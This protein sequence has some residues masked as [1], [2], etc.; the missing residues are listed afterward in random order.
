MATRRLYAA[1]VHL[2]HRRVHPP[3]SSRPSSSLVTGSNRA[4]Q[5]REQPRV[6]MGGRIIGLV[7]LLGAALLLRG[8]A[9]KSDKQRAAA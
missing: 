7:G 9:D 2:A 8:G 3:N 4:R 5:Q 1:A 6:S